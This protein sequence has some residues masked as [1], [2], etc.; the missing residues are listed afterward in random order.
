MLEREREIE[1]YPKEVS[2]CGK[3]KRPVRSHISAYYR[4]SIKRPIVSYTKQ[5]H[6]NTYCNLSYS[7]QILAASLSMVPAGDY[8]NR[9][10]PDRM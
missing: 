2:Y 6:N 4:H 5:Q 1:N 10:R 7:Q 3:R 8:T 9:R